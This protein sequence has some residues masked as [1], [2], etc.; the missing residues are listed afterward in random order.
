MQKRSKQTNKPHKTDAI[1]PVPSFGKLGKSP[2]GVDR[3][4]HALRYGGAAM[5]RTALAMMN[6]LG[7][8]EP[9][10]LDD[11][12]AQNAYLLINYMAD[13]RSHAEAP[14]GGKRPRTMLRVTLPDDTYAVVQGYKAAADLVGRNM[15]T[16]QQYVRNGNGRAHFAR[17]G[18]AQVYT[19][20]RL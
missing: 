4:S 5:L 20:E 18:S 3:A 15:V 17:K 12:N 16:V 1:A 8:L 14:G 13:A 7:Q 10:W 9:H 2:A 11:H 19:V 6:R